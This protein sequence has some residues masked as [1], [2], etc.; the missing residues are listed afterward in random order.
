MSKMSKSCNLCCRSGCFLA[1]SSHRWS[2]QSHS[3]A[4]FAPSAAL[5]DWILCAVLTVT[6][7]SFRPD[8]MCRIQSVS[9]RTDFFED[10]WSDATGVG[11]QS[12]VFASCRL[13][14]TAKMKQIKRKLLLPDNLLSINLH[15]YSLLLRTNTFNSIM[16][17]LIYSVEVT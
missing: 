8:F 9:L 1:W 13:F 3:W 16:S 11:P 6:A 12:S 4:V 2:Q 15:R 17:R 14:D 5:L 10:F 7:R